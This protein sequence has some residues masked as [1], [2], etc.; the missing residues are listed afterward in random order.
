M[1][2]HVIILHKRAPL[3]KQILWGQTRKNKQRRMGMDAIIIGVILAFCFVKGHNTY[4]LDTQNKVFNKRN[5]PL[6]DVKAYNQF[7]GKLIYAF[8]VAATLTMMIMMSGNPLISLLGCILLIAEA[9]VLVKIYAKKEL[10]FFRG[11]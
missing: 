4:N 11:Y 3:K 5:L 1:G 7:C 8:G 6:K 10:S 9:F 2:F